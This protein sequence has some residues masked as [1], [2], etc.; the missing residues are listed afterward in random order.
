MKRIVLSVLLCFPTLAF[1]A[2]FSGII[3]A[4]WVAADNQTSFI[5]SGTGA[6]R[7]D[8]SQTNLQQALINVSQDLGRDIQVNVTSNY[9]HDGEQN[10]GLSEAFLT[11]KPLTGNKHKWRARAGFFYPQMSLENVDVGWLSPYHYTQSAINSWV[12]E[13]LR[14]AG[15]EFSY[16]KPGRLNRSPWSWSVH[17]ALVKANDTLGTMLAWRGWSMHDRQSLNNDRVQFAHY[18]SVAYRIENPDWTEPFHEL[19][20]KTGYYLGAHL[21]YFNKSKL[22]YYFY[23]NN[24]NPLVVNHQRLYAWRTRFHSLAIQHNFSKQTR[25]IGQWMSGMTEMGKRWVYVN[26]DAWYLML[27]H[28]QDKHRFSIRYDKFKTREDDIWLWDP[29]DSDGHGVTVSWR[30][31]LTKNWQLGLEQ[32]FSSNDS[33]IRGTIN[34]PIEIDQQQTLAVL[35]Y[36]WR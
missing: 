23:D 21:S 30:Y 33:V 6:L 16:I 15:I 22:R 24:A 13:E 11:Y 14:A 29:N 25:L 5:N 8:E 26:Y 31:N 17:G 2:E 35:Q 27:S 7:Y 32:H 4:N 28:K 20:G 9:Y 19:D 34:E 1:A 3:Q 12:G 10:W 18:P 36:R